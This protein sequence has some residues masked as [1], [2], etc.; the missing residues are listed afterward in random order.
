MGKRIMYGETSERWAH[1]REEVVLVIA[2]EHLR[3]L[4]SDYK[5]FP[6]PSSPCLWEDGP[7]V[8]LLSFPF[9]QFSLVS[10]RH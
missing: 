3:G 2:V 4:T 5:R 7:L 6:L 8:R 9:A 10:Q 1:E